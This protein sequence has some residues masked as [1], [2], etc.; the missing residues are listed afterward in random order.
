[1]IYLDANATTPL[2]PEALAAIEEVLAQG[3]LNASSVHSAGQRARALLDLAREECA[4][5]LHCDPR[6]LIFTS[7]GTESDHLA[8]RGGALAARRAGHIVTT[9]VEHPAVLGA[10]AQLGPAGITTTRVPV[11]ASGAL[12]LDA[13][14]AALA[15]PGALLCSAMAANNETGVLFPLER[16]GELCCKHGVPLHVDAVQAAGRVPL[17]LDELPATYLSL[18]GHK[19]RGPQGIGLLWARRGA[20]LAAVQTGGHQEKGRR[21]GT[22]SVALAAG[23]ARALSLAV[24]DLPRSQPRLA[25]LRDRLET[26]ALAIPGTE[27]H[28]RQGPRLA[29]TLCASFA[30]CEGETLLVAL[31]LAS[32]CVSTGSACSSGSLE[33]SPVLLAMGVPEAR[34][35]GAL[36]FSLYSGNT[37]AEID[38]VAGLLPKLVAQ[39]R[40]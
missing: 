25:A 5:A 16:L 1:M 26:A 8:I 10:C 17:R 18:S 19:L 7:G 30:G 32:V 13:L 15:A 37:Q 14:D 24:N 35:R 11:D 31:D 34:A 23:L 33:P 36:R 9:A 40:R 27:V 39:C 22:E 38:R 6:E 20:P 29:N 2:R 28:G 3:P 21:A 4:A 12:D